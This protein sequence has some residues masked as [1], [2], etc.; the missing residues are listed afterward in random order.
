MRSVNLE[1]VDWTNC[2][3]LTIRCARVDEQRGKI[4]VDYL[5][6]VVL[7]RVAVDC[8]AGKNWFIGVD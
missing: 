7:T 2:S 1:R 8:K 3:V 5:E 4:G 6:M